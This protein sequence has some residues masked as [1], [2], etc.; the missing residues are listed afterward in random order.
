MI[1]EEKRK[2]LRPKKNVLPGPF[3]R[4]QLKSMIASL[5]KREDEV[6]KQI[7]FLQ[8]EKFDLIVKEKRLVEEENC[9]YAKDDKNNQHGA[10]PILNNQYQV[11]SLLGKGGFSEV[12]LVY[13]LDNFRKAACKLHILNAKWDNQIKKNYLKHILR[14]ITVFKKLNHPNI[15][16]YYESFQ[17]EN[18]SLI[19]ILE[20]SDGHDL[21]FILK[22]SGRLSEKDTRTLVKQ[23]VSAIKYLDT[24]NP[25]II[26]YDIKPQN[27]LVNTFGVAKLTDFGLCKLI[28]DESSKMELTS[29]GVGTYWYLPPESFQRDAFISNKVD[30]WSLGVVTYQM[31]YGRKPFG[32]QMTQERIHK[33]GIILQS[34]K[35]TFPEKPSISPQMRQFIISCLEYH[36]DSR[37]TIFEAEKILFN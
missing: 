9:L 13:D 24:Q 1:L 14:E 5:N 4:E 16:E 35:V 10:W 34:K 33:E 15:I 23:L 3:S 8:R 36:Q 19:T 6:N 30:V 32:H 11:L 20:Y 29:Q 37:V 31:L 17:L 7:S 12:Y 18:G 2:Q 21:D 25:K 22:K 26:H 28:Y 27:I